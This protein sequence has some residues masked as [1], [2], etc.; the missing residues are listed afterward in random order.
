MQEQTCGQ[1]KTVP[2]DPLYPRAGHCCIPAI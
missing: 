1:K 2:N